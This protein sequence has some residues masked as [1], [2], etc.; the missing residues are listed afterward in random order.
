MFFTA[1]SNDN[2]ATLSDKTVY[3]HGESMTSA[4]PDNQFITDS[5]SIK[6][7]WVDLEE[8]NSRQRTVD[9]N[10]SFIKID[11][12]AVGQSFEFNIYDAESLIGEVTRVSTD[13]NGV[14]S[15]SGQI[16]GD[17]G[18]FVFTVN[19]TLL[20]GQL[21]LTDRDKIIQIRFDDKLNDYILTESNRS[22]LDVLPG[23]AP[24]R[25]GNN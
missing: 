18:N 23:S 6:S 17:K 13:L 16:L 9:I 5:D 1:C 14:K 15:I 3:E 24:M 8:S 12:T 11:S 22:D 25:R 20:L 7:S 4:E 10:P 21:R 2:E 19:D